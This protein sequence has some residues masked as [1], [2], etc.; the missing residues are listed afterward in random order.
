MPAFTNINNDIAQLSTTVTDQAAVDVALWAALRYQH[1]QLADPV[2]YAGTVEPGKVYFNAATASA[3]SKF[4][5]HDQDMTLTSQYDMI[6]LEIVTRSRAFMIKKRD[7]SVCS[8]KYVSTATHTGSIGSGYWEINIVNTN[9]VYGSDNIADWALGVATDLNISPDQKLAQCYEFE[10]NGV[11]AFNPATNVW[12][13]VPIAGTMTVQKFGTM[14]EQPTNGLVG[15]KY[16]ASQRVL[17]ATFTLNVAVLSDQPAGAI[18]GV[19]M[20]LNGTQI[21]RVK[22]MTRAINSNETISWTDVFD[23]MPSGVYS[24]QVTNFGTPAVYFLVGDVHI[25]VRALTDTI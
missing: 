19:R 14:F 8:R 13:N 17:L 11:T 3:A 2:V 15:L 12:V 10:T 4:Y 5:I 20:L 22:A 23:G 25:T 1:W 16:V 18:I 21:G 9:A 7:G 24:F 6:N